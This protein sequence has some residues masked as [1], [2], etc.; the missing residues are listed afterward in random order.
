M[1][2]L[3][4]L[5]SLSREQKDVLIRQLFDLVQ[6]LT[7]RVEELEARLDSSGD[8]DGSLLSWEQLP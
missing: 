8:T 6:Q 4:D 2:E 7:A 5:S 1:K 3:P